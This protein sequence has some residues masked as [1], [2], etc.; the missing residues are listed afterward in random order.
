MGHDG[1]ES[2]LWVP[3]SAHQQGEVDYEDEEEDEEVGHHED[4]G[5]AEETVA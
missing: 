1:R 5:R 2:G 3:A 4:R